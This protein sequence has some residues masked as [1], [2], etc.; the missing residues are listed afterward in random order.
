M[1]KMYVVRVKRIVHNSF[2]ILLILSLCSFCLIVADPK[3]AHAATFT[4][5]GILYT[6]ADFDRAKQKVAMG[7][8]PW[9]DAWNAGKSSSFASPTYTPSPVAAPQRWG[10][11]PD[12]NQGNTQLFNDSEAAL[13]QAIIWKV[14]SNA[15]EAS[16]ARANAEK[17]LDAWSSTVNTAVGGDEKQLL[18]G[19]TGYR[20]AAAADIMRADS[21]WGGFNA[22]KNMLLTYFLPSLRDYLANHYGKNG[23]TYPYYYR[24]NQDI[25]AMASIMSIGILADNLTIY[26]EAVNDFKNGNYNGRVTYYLFGTSDPNLAQSEESGRDQAHTQLGIGTL[27]AMAQM[28]YNQH[29]GNS[30]IEDLYEYSNRLILQGFEYTAKYNMGGTVPFTPLYTSGTRIETTISSASRAQF[31]PIYE[32]VWNHYHYVDGL[33]DAA[34][35]DPVYNTKTVVDALRPEPIHTDHEPFT[36][37][38]YAQTPILSGQIYSFKNP[39][40]GKL[41][42]VAAAG[43]ANGTNVDIWQ[44]NGGDNQRFY[45]YENSD[46]TYKLIGVQSG[47]ALDV[48]SAGTADGTNVE[49]WTDNGGAN[50]KWRIVANSDGTYK[51]IDSNSGKALDVNGT[52]TAN[53]TNVQIWTD[54]G[55][56][57][58]KWQLIRGGVSSGSVY[59]LLNPNSGKVL[60]VAGGGT[61]NGAN[62]DILT[63]NSTS[64][65]NQQWTITDNGNGTFRLIGVQSGKA[66]DVTSGGN[67]DGTNVEIWTYSGG[68]NQ[69][70]KIVSYSDGTFKFVDSNSNKD[71]SVHGDGTADGTNVEISLNNGSPGQKWKVVRK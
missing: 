13:V 16:T 3:Q 58:Q 29:I 50:Q 30:A 19:I 57:S 52:G 11:H 64:A 40:S 68:A 23:T 4:H 60:D 20:L 51:F 38:L 1:K 54:N 44:D 55:R 33:A 35:T 59:A 63:D 26:N 14:S 67:A 45:L 71:L 12:L 7:V 6:Q 66:V 49:I 10:G 27:A 8:S 53:G 41:L 43:T 25:V 56:A 36:T 62:V 5:E 31:R 17:I 70:W 21:S 37:L 42:D 15:T 69:S 48:T 24:G 61:A 2:V 34:S 22:A 47:K 28:S 65:T 39:N 9:I 32:M 46:G 18:A